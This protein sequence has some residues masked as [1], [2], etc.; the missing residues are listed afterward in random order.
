MLYATLSSTV[1]GGALRRMR[2]F[3]ALPED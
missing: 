2:Q 3:P 1:P